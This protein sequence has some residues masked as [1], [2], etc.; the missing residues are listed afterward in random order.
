MGRNSERLVFLLSELTAYEK[1]NLMCRNQ[2][3]EGVY[4]GA[5]LPTVL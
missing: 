3:G 5:G 4:L 1:R 2:E